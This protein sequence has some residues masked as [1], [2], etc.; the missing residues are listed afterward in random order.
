[1][2]DVSIRPGD[3][4]DVSPWCVSWT[5]RSGARS[6]A[7]LELKL[8]ARLKAQTPAPTATMSEHATTLWNTFRAVLFP[9]A[10]NNSAI[11]SRP[12]RPPLSGR[13]SAPG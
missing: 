9:F 2:P 4:T 8:L 3:P 12:L 11:V 6:R 13:P 5:L 1:M 10:R 7:W